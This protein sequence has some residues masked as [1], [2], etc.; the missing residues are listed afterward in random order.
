MM[1]YARLKRLYA[2]GLLTEKGLRNAVNR[3]WIMEE[4][5]EDIIK[6]VAEESEGGTEV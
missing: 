5:M 6:E 4:E 3:G 1:D 2:Q